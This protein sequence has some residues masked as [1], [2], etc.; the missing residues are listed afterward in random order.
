MLYAAPRNLTGRP[1]TL[2]SRIGFSESKTLVK[3]RY[4]SEHDFSDLDDTIDRTLSLASQ[5][6]GSMGF[7]GLTLA[8]ERVALAWFSV[9]API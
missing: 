3:V 5:L 6:H 7:E 9:I 4:V 8:K 1:G 2:T